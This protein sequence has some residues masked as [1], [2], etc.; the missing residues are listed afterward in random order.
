MGILEGR[1]QRKNFN[2]E[3]E[4]YINGFYDDY[5]YLDEYTT[6]NKCD[7]MLEAH[8]YG[9]DVSSGYLKPSDIHK[10]KRYNR[11]K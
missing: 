11:D 7:L 3:W 5:D 1:T 10:I 8:C 2:R 9:I 4:A 6:G